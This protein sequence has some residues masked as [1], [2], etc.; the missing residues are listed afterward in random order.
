MEVRESLFLTTLQFC[1]K[2]T[3]SD[4]S[5]AGMGKC[6]EVVRLR[7]ALNIEGPPEETREEQ[8]GKRFRVG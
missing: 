5:G 3:L 7:G 6:W 8:G 2:L 4:G 1:R